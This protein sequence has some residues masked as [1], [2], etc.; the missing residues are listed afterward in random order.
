M[1][2]RT[3]LRR[4]LSGADMVMF[5]L[6]AMVPLAPFGAFGQMY[7]VS[8][9]MIALG[10]LAGAAV[11]VVTAYGYAAL[12]RAAPSA[13]SVYHFGTALI[14]RP[15]GFLGGWVTLLCYLGAPT[16]ACVVTGYTLAG[17]VPAV[18]WWLWAVVFVGVGGAVNCLGTRVTMR[19]IRVLLAVELFI[20]AVVLL[21]GVLTLAMG[22][23][24]GLRLT[25]LY[26]PATFTAGT[27]T[28]S[29]ALAVFGF[30]GF[31]GVATL[32][33]ESR[34]GTARTARA[35]VFAALAAAAVFVVQSW[36]FT[37]FVDPETSGRL[38]AEGDPAGTALLDIATGFGGPLVAV[39]C[40]VALSL[41]MGMAGVPV[42]ASAAR[43]LYAM[44]RDG[45]LPG[46]LARLSPRRGVPATA[47]V[48]GAAVSA[49]GVG[50]MAFGPEVGAYLT[51]TV[52]DA[53]LGMFLLVH[54]CWAVHL[55]R[56]HRR[57]AL[58]RLLAPVGGAAVTVYLLY[59]MWS[60]TTVVLGVWLLA[61][62]A[63]LGYG[64]LR[65]RRTAAV[66]PGHA[67]GGPNLGPYPFLWLGR[68]TLSLGE[69]GRVQALVAVGYRHGRGDLLDLRF[70]PDDTPA[71]QPFLDGLVH[72]GLAGVRLVSS[73]DH[74]GL[75]GAVGEALPAARWLWR[76][77]PQTH[78][79][80]HRAA[81][82]NQLWMAARLRGLVDEHDT[83]G[84]RNR[85]TAFVAA[86][87]AEAPDLADHLW[88][89]RDE[90]VT[91][92]LCAPDAPCDRRH[93]PYQASRVI[94]RRL[95]GTGAFA[96]EA[97]AAAVL[98]A[99]VEHV[100]GSRRT[101]PIGG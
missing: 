5:G 100:A 101:A 4:S 69:G 30:V 39:A 73:D 82:E 94:Q 34:D 66:R 89:A 83:V 86:L 1:A 84:T 18:P 31:D 62:L 21:F 71:W 19:V 33:E 23:N 79:L 74:E 92:P 70:H 80:V 88:A 81:P 95:D 27:V 42:Q 57:A 44:A 68:F 41:A 10:Y 35:I 13:G 50:L 45:H 49:S 20:L 28:G 7:Q 2:T 65:R 15:V 51:D 26:D 55:V 60:P 87:R 6:V 47:T 93:S 3:R 32:A 12:T 90:L 75:S 76:V 16:L 72:R 59:R 36:V 24:Q 9:G 61:G 67:P 98:T 29:L 14:G 38:L 77:L 43:I 96:H 40:A 48:V 25:P 78:D 63:A 58:P 53:A 91:H 97:H 46:R 11:A 37:L 22:V 56:T 54:V 64:W 17:L 52:F 99:L 85:L 8:G